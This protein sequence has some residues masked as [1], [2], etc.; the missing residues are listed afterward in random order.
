[1]ELIKKNLKIGDWAVGNVKN[2]FHYDAD[3]FEFERAQR[4]EM[5]VPDF[6][7]RITGVDEGGAAAENPFGFYMFAEAGPTMHDNDH[8]G[9]QDED[10]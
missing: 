1:M 4:A 2:L 9:R 8:R 6:D 3:F 10:E 7:G 5:G